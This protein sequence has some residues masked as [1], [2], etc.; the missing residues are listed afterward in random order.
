MAYKPHSVQGLF[1]FT[2]YQFSET[3]VENLDGA[4]EAI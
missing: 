3:L 4:V 1:D 2:I